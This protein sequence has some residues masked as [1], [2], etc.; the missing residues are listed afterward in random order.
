MKTKTHLSL[1]SCLIALLTIA[2]KSLA[3]GESIG[4]PPNDC[5]TASGKCATTPTKFTTTVYR[6]ALCTSS[7]ME[8]PSTTVNW[9]SAGCSDVYNN[10]NGETTGDILSG[11]GV[12]LMSQ[13][14]KM[15]NP[16]AYSKVVALVSNS[17][18]MA[19]NHMVVAAGTNN[20]VNRTRYISTTAGGAIAGASGN[21]APY[22]VAVNTFSGAL[23]C[24]GAYV[25]PNSWSSTG[26]SGNGFT[27]RLLKSNY[28]MPVS[29]SGNISDGTAKCDGVAYILAII[30]K[31]ITVSSSAIGINLRI[32]ATKGSAL[33]NQGTGDGI[34]TGF[35]GTG[36]SLTF[37]ISMF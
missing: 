23:A 11:N 12:D 10:P 17:F 8:S 21:E 20:P 16:G 35:S 1:A 2:T 37:D 15:P 19:S 36:S 32:R 26:V 34:V 18:S 30:S 31:Q 24:S 7:P 5:N 9:D 29:G 22:N 27:G 14:I 28:E 25:T 4:N 6:I 33:V 3:A 13:Y